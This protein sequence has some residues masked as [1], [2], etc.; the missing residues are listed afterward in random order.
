MARGK[1]VHQGQTYYTVGA[2]AKLLRTNVV[3]V[4]ELMGNG[5]LEWL[6]LSV[7]GHIVIP[8]SSLQTCLQG[9]LAKSERPTK[10]RKEK[11]NEFD[12]IPTEYTYG[13]LLNR[14]VANKLVV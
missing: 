12:F 4:K 10:P 11:P 13:P 6:N 9:M 7:N 1:I 5:S 8:Q 2:A 3:K 14:G